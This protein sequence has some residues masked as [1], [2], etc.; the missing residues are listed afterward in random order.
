MNTRL[1]PSLTVAAALALGGCAS[2][3]PDQ[4]LGPAIGITRAELAKDV[5]K[6]TDEAVASTAQ[7]RA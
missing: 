6:V 7:E 3:T 5:V 1:S 2:F 4:G